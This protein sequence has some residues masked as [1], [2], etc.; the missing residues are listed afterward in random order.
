M[1]LKYFD[2][3]NIEEQSAVVYW[4]YS[5]YPAWRLGSALRL[6][7]PVSKYCDWVREPVRF[8]SSVSV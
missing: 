4:R 1:K 7:G 2:I 6:V 8:A 5:G 3:V